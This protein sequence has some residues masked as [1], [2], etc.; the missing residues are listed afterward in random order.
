MSASSLRQ[1]PIGAR[2]LLL[3]QLYVYRRTWTELA[4]A[5]IE[6][7]MYLL[8]LGIGLGKLVGHAPGLPHVSYATYVAPGLLAMAVMNAATN[9]TIFGA[10]WRLR[11]SKLYEVVVVT[12]ISVADL[13]RAEFVWATVRG[14]LAGAGFFAVMA[15]FGLVHS[16]DA[17]LVVPFS[18]LVAVAFGT[19][20]LVVATYVRDPRDFQ[21]VQ[22]V[23]LPMFLFA[24]TFYPLSVYPRALQ[25][26][27]AC[28]PLYHA[29]NLVRGPAL[30]TIDGDVLVAVVYLVAMTVAC[31]WFAVRRL[32]LVL[33]R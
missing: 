23:M 28:L 31:W 30:G 1:R 29:I 7:L 27:V 14:V 8:T 15:L 32:T 25:I 33:I 4:A 21:W 16:A 24:T 13:A 5:V 26:V 18:A 19:A 6:P 22:L 3:R 20:G 11:R 17:L 12:P 9:E 2:P 10:F